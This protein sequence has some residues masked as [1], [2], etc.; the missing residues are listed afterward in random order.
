M[1]DAEIEKIYTEGK[2]ISHVGGLRA[3]F[4]AGIQSTVPVAPPVVEPSPETATAPKKA[5]AKMK[6]KGKR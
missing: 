1:D 5:R 4:N 6:K 3:V 2:T